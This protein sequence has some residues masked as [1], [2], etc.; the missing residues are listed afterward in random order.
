MIL[1]GRYSAMCRSNRKTMRLLLA[2][3][4]IAPPVIAQEIQPLV[5]LWGTEAQCTGALITPKGTKRATP[6]DVRPDWLGKGDVWCR[7]NWTTVQTTATDTVAIAQAVCGE[8]AVRDY[9]LTFRLVDDAL[10]INWDLFFQNGPIK[11]CS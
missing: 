9:R 8:D 4:F 6:F 10:T 2:L 5:G 3:V 1:S 11:R 7:L